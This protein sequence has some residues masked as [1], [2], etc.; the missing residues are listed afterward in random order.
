MLSKPHEAQRRPPRL[1]AGQTHRPAPRGARPA[2]PEW[3]SVQH[4]RDIQQT[5]AKGRLVGFDSIANAVSGSAW[6]YLLIAAVCAGDALLPLFPS[7]TVVVTAA[8]LAANGRLHI[9]LL[10]VAAAVGAFAGDN[11]AYAVG[12]SGLKKLARRFMRSDKS[13]RRIE[14]SR[15]QLRAHGGWI[16]IAARFIPG[17]RTATTYVSGTLE[18]PWR[19]RFA[20][21]DAVAAVL[22]ACY[23]SALGYFGGAAFENNLWLP[24]LIAAGAS[25]VVTG[26]G[27]LLRRRLSAST[28]RKS[29]SKA[30]RAK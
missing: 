9:I 10:G 16:I 26:G 24:L 15:E 25:I 2:R 27:E 1:S 21:A 8:V 19:R 4:P 23:C 29:S 30:P 14:W 18:M 12:R 11:C 6:T 13:K 3:A 5:D 22:W 7:E 28:K 20:P 17:G